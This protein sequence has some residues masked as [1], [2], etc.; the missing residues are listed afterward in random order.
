MNSK[1]WPLLLLSI[2]VLISCMG[3]RKNPEIDAKIP[4]EFWTS[5]TEQDRI[6]TQQQLADRFSKKFPKYQVKIIGVQEDLL[7]QRLAAYKAGGR[8]PE[9]V[10]IGMEYTSGYVDDNLL[11]TKTAGEVISELGEDSFFSGPLQLLKHGNKDYAAVP[12]DGWG[13]CIWYRKDWF[14]SKNLEPP[15]SWRTLLLAA[16]TFHKPAQQIYGIVLG[17][18][19]QQIYTQQTFEHLALSNGLY[20]FNSAGEFNPNSRRLQETLSFYKQL[21]AFCPPGNNSW[22]EARKYYLTERAAMIF[23]SP[24]IVDDIAGFADDHQPTENLARHTDLVS[25]LKGP[26]GDLALYGQ[27]ESLGITPIQDEAKRQAAKEWVKYLLTEGYLDVCFMSP[28][29]KVPI[30]KHVVTRWQSHKYFSLYPPGLAERL[31]QAMDDIERW[32]WTLGHRSPLITDI[33][34]QKLF[35]ALLG[36]L[37]EDKIKIEDAPEWLNKRVNRITTK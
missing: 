21:A 31:A 28:G 10:R 7:P 35:P 29:G 5:D 14:E 6:E 32:G 4:I 13:Q 20:L 30:R 27:I 16:E 37:L 25:A 19:P 1:K 15:S 34:G 36:E 8:L 23:Y 12:I 2:L 18:D 33:Y 9:V 26:H 11:D 24:Y 17:T 3:C 22:R